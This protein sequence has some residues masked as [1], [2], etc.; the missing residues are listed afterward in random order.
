M[1]TFDQDLIDLIDNGYST[2]Y[3]DLICSLLMLLNNI[4]LHNKRLVA[5][6]DCYCVCRVV[7]STFLVVAIC[8]LMFCVAL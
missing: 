5:R 6:L 2:L 4:S 8:L 7:Y 3:A 1:V